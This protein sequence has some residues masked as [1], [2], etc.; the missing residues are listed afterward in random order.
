ML[1]FK[2]IFQSFES[3]DIAQISER[4]LNLVV[5]YRVQEDRNRPVPVSDGDGDGIIVSEA[6][7]KKV[8]RH[9]RLNEALA[10]L[11]L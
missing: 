3:A 6:Q 8:F 4:S 11:I 1:L 10:P 9:W 7:G 2:E 5:E